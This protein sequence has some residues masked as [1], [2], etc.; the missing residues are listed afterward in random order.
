MA[1]AAA[2]VAPALRLIGENRDAPPDNARL[3]AACGLGTRQFPH[4]FAA[5]VG[6]SPAR[7]GWERRLALAAE[8]LTRGE[9]TV[10][11]VAARP[12]FADRFHSSKAFRA[13]VGLPP[14]SY[15][16]LHGWRSAGG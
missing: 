11:E 1:G 12:G 9:E 8:A 16:R 3:A 6:L 7:Y 2:V 10:D 14:A 13:R 4:R 5:V 15:R